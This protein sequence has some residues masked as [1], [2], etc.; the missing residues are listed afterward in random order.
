MK[1]HVKIGLCLCSLFLMTSCTDISKLLVKNESEKV[2]S[3]SKVEANRELSTI[4][5]QYV[6]AWLREQPM[7]IKRTAF[8]G[9][10]QSKFIPIEKTKQDSTYIFYNKESFFMERKEQ[11]IFQDD[12]TNDAFTLK[13][14]GDKLFFGEEGISDEKIKTIIEGES[15]FYQDFEGMLQKNILEK[16]LLNDKLYGKVK[17][18]EGKNDIIYKFKINDEES[19][20]ERVSIRKFS[21][22][23]EVRT[24]ENDYETLTIVELLRPNSSKELPHTESQEI[25]NKGTKADRSLT[26]GDDLFGKSI[27]V[28]THGFSMIPIWITEK[29]FI[30]LQLYS[31]VFPDLEIKLEIGNVP[32]KDRLI[33][34]KKQGNWKEI[35]EIQTDDFI[36]TLYEDSK[37][38]RFIFESEKGNFSIKAQL[39]SEKA[40]RETDQLIFEKVLKGIYFY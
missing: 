33:Y 13:K 14:E 3:L 24:Q 22:K 31:K 20:K 23:L 36:G 18:V 16:L 9:E 2:I 4:Y 40:L 37:N 25:V 8:S 15:Y 30:L 7:S 6:E 5:N 1:K 34:S 17:K 28:D 11:T 29:N 10:K 32:D 39:F 27:G 26:I 19:G 38:Q 21:N 12:I 35:K